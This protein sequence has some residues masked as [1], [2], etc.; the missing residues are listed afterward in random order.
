MDK[1]FCF[2]SVFPPGKPP[3]PGRAACCPPL[4]WFRGI[5]GAHRVP[6]ARLRGGCPAEFRPG[7]ERAPPGAEPALPPQRQ[8]QHLLPSL[9]CTVLRL[10]LRPHTSTAKASLPGIRPFSSPVRQNPSFSYRARA[11]VFPTSTSTVRMPGNLARA[12]STK[13]RPMPRRMCSGFTYS[14]ASSSS[15]QA[16]KPLTRP[17]SS[18][19]NRPGYAKSPSLSPAISRG[20]KASSSPASR[21]SVFLAAS[22]TAPMACRS[23]GL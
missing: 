8:G 14:Q 7:P 15:V 17:P 13:P 22:C 21:S 5:R 19:T 16:A 6:Q 23:S 11:G 10:A 1:A 9:F 18:A 4:P 20:R 2:G 12:N 3:A